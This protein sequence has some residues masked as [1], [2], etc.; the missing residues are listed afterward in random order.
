MLLDS[1][2]ILVVFA[3]MGGALSAALII[4]TTFLVDSCGLGGRGGLLVF[5]LGGAAIL[6]WNAKKYKNID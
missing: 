1:D 3:G 6:L 2:A 4:L 5:E